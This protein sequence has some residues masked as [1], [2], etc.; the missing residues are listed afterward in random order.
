[1]AKVLSGAWVVGDEE[2][3]GPGGSDLEVSTADIQFLR[4]TTLVEIDSQGFT[5]GAWSN[6]QRDGA[7]VV[8]RRLPAISNFS[9]TRKLAGGI[10]LSHSPRYRLSELRATPTDG[11]MQVALGANRWTRDS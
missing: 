6:L 9:C 8:C 11:E 2:G 3:G 5:S 7:D 10:T 4:S 1:M